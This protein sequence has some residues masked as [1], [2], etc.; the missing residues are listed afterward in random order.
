MIFRLVKPATINLPV[1]VEVPDGEAATIVLRVKYLTNSEVQVLLR[2]VFESRRLIREPKDGELPTIMSDFDLA[3][4]LVVGWGRVGDE[5]GN[6]IP[7]S[8]QALASA[9][10]IRY[11]QNAVG[12]ALLEHLLNGR[13]KNSTPLAANGL[14]E[15]TT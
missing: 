13:K 15:S 12:D 7:F 9:M 2:E 10:D 8:E 3:K 1:P 5:E 6:E 14:E 4:R 11:F